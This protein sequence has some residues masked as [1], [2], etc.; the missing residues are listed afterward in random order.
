MRKKVFAF[1]LALT[2]LM[3]T[4]PA[5]ANATP[6]AVDTSSL[7]DSLNSGI[8]VVVVGNYEFTSQFSDPSATPMKTASE[9]TGTTT[10]DFSNNIVNID[11]LINLPRAY[12]GNSD[13]SLTAIIISPNVIGTY[14]SENDEKNALES[15][16]N[17][18]NIVYFP[19]TTYEDM[20]GIFNAV[21]ND[22]FNMAPVESG[23]TDNITAY[24]FKD[25]AGAYYTGNIIAPVSSSQEN[26]DARIIV[27]TLANSTVF[28]SSNQPEEFE[29]GYGWNQVSTWHKNSYAGDASGREWLSE[30]ICFFSA[31]TDDGDHYY[32]WAGEWC[33]E[34]YENWGTYLASD[35]VKYESDCSSQ[36]SGIQLRDYWPTSTPGSATGSVSIGANTDKVFDIGISFDWR[37]D[38]LYFTDNSSP[39]AEFCGLEWNFDH[40]ILSNY[41]KEVSYGN[42]AMIFKDTERAGSYTFHHYRAAYQY[43]PNIFGEGTSG[44]YKTTYDFAP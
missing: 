31:Q 40:S 26:I 6:S 39:A 44:N 3:G 23:I 30:W 37:I 12:A 41:D 16:L 32:A 33:M 13:S 11:S 35:Y 42:F 18:G 38:E 28:A 29:P 14:L 19:E 2:I 15:M 17:A 24:V 43:A 27:E 22:S 8:S 9:V 25:A 7:Q 20:T 36:Q 5:S 21:A 34:P 10:V 4:L 1:A